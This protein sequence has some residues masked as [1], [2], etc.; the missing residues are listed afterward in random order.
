MAVIPPV[1]GL[2]IV[3]IRGRGRA[4]TIG[5]IGFGVA[6]V[7]GLITQTVSILL[8]RILPS[9]GSSF[10][11]VNTLWGIVL[12][13]LHVIEMVIL[14]VAI[15]VNRPAVQPAQPGPYG[16]NRPPTVG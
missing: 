14:A 9:L 5:L 15:V 1:V 7:I 10:A 8:P 16:Y 6:A 4:R 11:L 12:M 13:I 3:A 2:I